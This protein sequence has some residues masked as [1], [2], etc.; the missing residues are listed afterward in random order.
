MISVL[1]E[2]GGVTLQRA[3]LGL[4][5]LVLAL[6]VVPAGLAVERRLALALEERTRADLALAVRVLDDRWS[7][8]ATVRM[9]HAKDLASVAALRDALAV[10]NVQGAEEAV[11]AVALAPLEEPVL[12]DGQ[13]RSRT[14]PVPPESLVEATRAGEMPVAVVVED[15]RMTV[16]ALAPVM[17]DGVWLGAAGVVTPLDAGEA[18]TLSGLTRADV[19]LVRP[20]GE[21]AAST[22]SDGLDV[23]VA[24]AL[25]GAVSD[26]VQDVTVDSRR[27]VAA[28][29]DLAGVATAIF[30]RDLDEEL[31]VVPALRR[32]AAVSIILA[33]LLALVAGVFVAMLL[34][35]PV[36]ALARD[37]DRFA[38]GDLSA[39]VHAG[40]VRE[41]RKV[42]EALD[43]MRQRL[44]GRVRQL[45]DANRELEDRQRRLGLLQ[46]E[47]VQRDRLAAA[48]RLLAQL[49]HEI[50]NPVATVRNCLELLRRR[51]EDDAEAR[52]FADMAIDELLGMHELAEQMMDL[53]RPKEAAPTSDV[54]EVAERV[55]RLVRVGAADGAPEIDVMGDAGPVRMAPE[56]L[57]Q[58]LLNV[59]MNAGEAAGP[60][61]AVDI[62]IEEAEGAVWID[63][64]DDGPG[65]P[66]AA[67]DRIFDP[68]FTTKDAVRGVGLGLFTA[69]GLVRTAGGRIAAMN[70]R[71]RS[72]A[73]FRIELPAARSVDQGTATR[74]AAA[75]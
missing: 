31:A 48:G 38:S 17:A 44:D 62:S 59:V 26:S 75:P 65:I 39:P 60:Q 37:A 4:I 25:S 22:M 32:A 52:E 63:V 64:L 40:G 69:E 33:S 16:M 67:L 71:D 2:V 34:A 19:V 35:R 23:R 42:A 72:G 73:H 27:L 55:A 1:A 54:I 11:R 14:G 6:A 49:A 18:S 45:E 61:G 9:M 56:T 41:V 58:V 21:V 28:P 70:R 50:R 8:G 15:D 10:G 51:V 74:T 7:Q 36:H 57:K 24:R 12:V 47:L 66:D 20:D 46:A 68:F 29:G 5:V 53:H 43:V 30:V 13:G 3:L